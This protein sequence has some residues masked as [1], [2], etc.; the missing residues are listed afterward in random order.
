MAFG[1]MIMRF[2]PLKVGEACAEE[3][4]AAGQFPGPPR[5]RPTHSNSQEAIR[6]PFGYGLVR[7]IC[8]VRKR[9]QHVEIEMSTNNT[10]CWT[11]IPVL[12][13]DRA[14][15]FYS[16]VLGTKVTKE[17][18]PGFEFGLLPHVEN[19]VSGCLCRM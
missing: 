5:G 19:N 10:I 13:L 16:A 12:D 17:S 8:P 15:R 1:G 18:S 11:D 9:H 3:A 4:G 6:P 2:E 7:A 14:I